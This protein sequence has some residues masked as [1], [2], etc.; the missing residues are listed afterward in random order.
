MAGNMISPTIKLLGNVAGLRID[1]HS[2]ITSNLANIETP[3][4]QTKEASFEKQLQAALPAKGQL[5]MVKTD[6]R[7]MPLYD[8]TGNVEAKV[9]TGGDVDV[10]KQMAKLA[11]NNLMYNAM[12]QI[13][14]RKYRAIKDAID[15]G[16]R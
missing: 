3:G 7:H 12:V 13:L 11:E 10:D 5:K 2:L 15:Q 4:Y 9:S 8:R 1:R 14:G 6:S 16:G